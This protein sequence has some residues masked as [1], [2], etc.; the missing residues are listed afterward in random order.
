MNH[1]IRHSMSEVC[2]STICTPTIKPNGST[3]SPQDPSWQRYLLLSSQQEVLNRRLSLQI[4]SASPMTASSPEMQSLASS[5]T[6]SRPSFTSSFSCEPEATPETTPP[7][8]ASTQPMSAYPIPTQPGLGHGRAEN[9]HCDDSKSACEINQQIKA[10]LTE[11]L[12]T[13]S[14]RSD[15]KYRAWIQDRLMNAERQIR[16]DRRRRSSVDREIAQS[17]ADHFE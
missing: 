9:L 17:I 15:E 3:D 11:L 12:N 1:S 4:P 16:R 10:T 8:S 5:P 13:E 14:V 2:T 6:Y 7:T